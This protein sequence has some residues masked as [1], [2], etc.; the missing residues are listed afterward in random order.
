MAEK[1]K[2]LAVAPY[3]GLAAILEREARSYDNL[4]MTIVVGNLEEGVA[5]A[6]D[7]LV[8]PF[9]LVL[10]RGG[11][12]DLLREQLDLPIVDI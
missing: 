2:I 11:T 5:A 4:S 8:E 10:S 7:Q 6:I 12:A 1:V 9:D 3:E